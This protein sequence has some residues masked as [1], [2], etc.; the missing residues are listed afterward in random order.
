MRNDLNFET[1]SSISRNF[2]AI[3]HRCHPRYSIALSHQS[4]RVLQLLNEEQAV[5]VQR[6]AE[7][8]GCAANTAS[9]LVS[10][11]VSKRLVEKQRS[12][13]DER[14]VFL[15]LT[16]IGR[17]AFDEHVGLDVSRLA[18]ALQ[19]CDLRTKHEIQTAFETLLDLVG[20]L[21]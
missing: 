18:N 11:L 5:T 8:L 2:A 20:K 10:R 19:L 9:E 17:T 14:V 1:A 21:K 15:R 3:Y 16:D 7:F 13:D 12:E 4:V 6:V